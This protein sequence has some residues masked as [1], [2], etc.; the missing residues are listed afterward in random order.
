[1]CARGAAA[2]RLHD[3]VLSYFSCADVGRVR[4]DSAINGVMRGLKALRGFYIAAD[5]AKARPEA[6][7]QLKA[8]L[9]VSYV[10]R[11]LA[12]ICCAHLAHVRCAVA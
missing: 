6:G 8:N 11:A 4:A 12:I 5:A 2:G 10:A 7:K 1:M 9:K 3:S